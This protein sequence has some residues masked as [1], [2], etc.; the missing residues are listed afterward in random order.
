M[1]ASGFGF[2]SRICDNLAAG[3]WVHPLI[4]RRRC[5]LVTRKRSSEMV[6]VDGKRRLKSLKQKVSR[7]TLFDLIVRVMNGFSFLRAL[8][9]KPSLEFT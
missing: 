4:I 6:L 7:T 1:M 2:Q 5:V 9:G 3:V 8:R